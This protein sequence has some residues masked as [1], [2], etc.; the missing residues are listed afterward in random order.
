MI[1]AQAEC[2]DTEFLASMLVSSI[3]VKGGMFAMYFIIHESDC[4]SYIAWRKEWN[5]DVCSIVSY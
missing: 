4:D 3:Y 2:H 1:S 5:S